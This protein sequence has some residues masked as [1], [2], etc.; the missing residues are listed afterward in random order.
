MFRLLCPF[1]FGASVILLSLSAGRADEAK[2]T[3]KPGEVLAMFH[4]GTKVRMVI[5]QEKLEV[6]TRYGK[7]TVPTT[8][9]RRVE[10]GFRVPEDAAKKLEESIA[11]L[12]SANYPEREAATKNLINLGRLAYPSLLK[13]SKGNDLETTKRIEDILKEIRQKVPSEQLRSRTDDLIHT[14]EF[15]IAGRIDAAQL[16]AR[17]E[18]FGEVQIKVVDLRNLYSTSGVGEAKATVDAVTYGSGNNQWLDTGYH[19][20]AESPLLITATG[21]VD[22]YGNQQPGMYISGPDGNR[23]V[24]RVGTHIP[25]MLLGRIGDDG[26][27]FIV[28]KK[29]EGSPTQE[30]KLYLRIVPIQNSGGSTGSYQ[31]KIA[32]GSAIPAP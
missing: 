15:V 21:E 30:G 12:G 2:K 3:G 22:L 29:Y 25:G 18:H 27:V 9:I 16:K 24:G 11:N 31:V 26:P 6:T 32:S 17:S 8:E 23:N 28:S 19:V 20:S 10:F 13:A 14:S 4:D 1:L 5:L 7:L